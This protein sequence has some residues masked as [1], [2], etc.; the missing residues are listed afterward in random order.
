MERKHQA[1]IAVLGGGPAG[2]LT[3]MRLA[4][5][6]H[7]ITLVSAPRRRPAIEGLS[8]RVVEILDR[9][10]CRAALGAL[11]A[12]VERVAVWN[13]EAAVRNRE[14]IAD[15]GALDLGLL[16]D[17]RDRGVEILEAKAGRVSLHDEGAE[18]A[19]LGTDG[20][21]LAVACR[22]LVE[23]RG[24][25]APAPGGRARR[26]PETTAL[27]RVVT[28][29]AGPP[30]TVVA[31]FREGWLWY[32]TLGRGTGVLQLVVDSG[33]DMLPARPALTGFYLAQLA[34]LDLPTD[35]VPR[36]RFAGATTSRNATSWI[37][38][39]LITGSAIRVGD[40]AVAVD[41]LSGHGIFEAL[42]SALAASAAVHTIL[43]RSDSAAIARD[44]Y[45]ERASD[46]F[47]RYCRV[48][49][50]FYA[51]ET[52]WPTRP[53]WQRRAAWPDDAPAHRGMASAAPR[54]ALKPVVEDGFV[55]AREVCVTPDHPR[56][57]WRID[58][59]PVVDL[60]RLIRREAPPDLSTMTE[61]AAMRL[62]AAPSKVATA[63]SWLRYRRILRVE[64]APVIAL[65]GL[66]D[67]RHSIA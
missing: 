67:R 59:V 45:V 58:D 32:V 49:R 54:V 55:V 19:A 28:D 6:G 40:A 64:A 65:E 8:P 1:D 31:S 23:A 7:R 47:D 37:A 43:M 15:R 21:S 50:D 41:P 35:L 38:R 33:E 12:T 10:R 53:F 30:R 11:G 46:A 29:D 66:D 4:D 9:H 27:A 36:G 60:A 13:G 51:M 26:G 61:L 18:I 16:E 57:V 22:Y 56:G 62:G 39:R 3:A 5:L 48:G 34:D 24:R 14:T 20:R 63:L 2:C 25:R 44:F 52:R 17:A 42:G